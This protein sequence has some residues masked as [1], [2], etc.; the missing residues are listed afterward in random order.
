LGE[1]KYGISLTDAC[2]GW[3]VTERMLRHGCERLR[4]VRRELASA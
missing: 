1:L 3:D 2:L 4:A